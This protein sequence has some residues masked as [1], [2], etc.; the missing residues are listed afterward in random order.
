MKR[1]D[2]H[3]R[4]VA[5]QNGSRRSFSKAASA[6]AAAWSFTA[7]SYGRIAGANDR[8]SIGIIGCGDRGLKAHMPGIN[9]H[10]KTQNL[11]IT[12]VCDPWIVRR[13]MASA[14]AKEWYGR[15]ARMFVSYRDLVA[16]PDVDAVMIAS[17]DHWH[18]THLE[19]AAKAKKDVYCEKPLAKDLE[20]LKSACDAVQA[21]RVVFQVGTQIRSVPT[22]AGCRELFQSGAWA[23]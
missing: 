9:A 22:T 2:C 10:A 14:Q 15:P 16:L 4:V 20:G 23:N 17:P 18:T 1:L 7:S 13:E 6:G 5:L 11:Q 12:A 21:N 19:A 8:L 3:H